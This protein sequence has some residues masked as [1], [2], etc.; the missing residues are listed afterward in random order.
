MDWN[1]SP[2]FCR[3]WIQ[4]MTLC[5]LWNQRTGREVTYGEIRLA[6][7]EQFSAYSFDYADVGSLWKHLELYEGGVFSAAGEGEGLREDGCADAEAFSGFGC[8]RTGAEVL[9]C[10]QS[11][12]CARGDLCDGA[13]WGDGADSNTGGWRGEG[14]CG[15][16]RASESA[17]QRVSESASGC[18]GTIMADFLFEVGLEEVPAR[19][20]AGAQAE[21]EQRVVKMLERER[22]VRSGATTKSFA[23]PRR[24][25]VWVKDVVERQGGR[26]RGIGGAFDEGGLIRMGWRP[27]RRRPLRR[28]LALRWKSSRRLRMQ[29]GS[30]SRRL[31]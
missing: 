4:S 6:E 25:A 9:A 7:E 17:S 11:A 18:L 20:I 29:R 15:A 8:L 24:L 26:C 21:L 30:I 2:G 22:L 23:T 10:V 5:G 31:Q 16:G 13:G 19:M 14:L 28:R 1:G 12:G 27:R 3:M